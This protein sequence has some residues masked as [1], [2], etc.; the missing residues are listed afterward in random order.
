M[1]FGV[2]EGADRRLAKDAAVAAANPSPRRVLRARSSV[3]ERS[4]HTR[5]A[6]ISPSSDSAALGLGALPIRTAPPA[7]PDQRRLEAEAEH[8]TEE[9]GLRAARLYSGADTEDSVREIEAELDA[10]ALRRA[11]QRLTAQSVYQGWIRG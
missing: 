10:V 9:L 6:R 3:G 1:D 2:G 7:W 11:E 5:L 4:P 8:L